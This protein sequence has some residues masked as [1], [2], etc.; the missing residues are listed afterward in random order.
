MAFIAL[1]AGS[2]FYD[3]ICCGLRDSRIHRPRAGEHVWIFHRRLITDGIAFTGYALN[4]MQ[5]RAVKPSIQS[6]PSIVVEVR[7]VHNQRISLPMSDGVSVIAKVR[8]RVVRAA[9][10]RH[11]TK[12]IPRDHLVEEYDGHPGGLNDGVRWTYARNTP[13][14]TKKGRVQ[15]ALV[16]CQVLYLFE[17]LR[18]VRRLIGICKSRS[19]SV[20]APPDVRVRRSETTDGRIRPGAARPK[21]IEI[22]MAVGES[23]YRPSRRHVWSRLW[24]ASSGFLLGGR[25]HGSGAQN[26]EHRHRCQA[27]LDRNL[28]VDSKTGTIV[29]RHFDVTVCVNTY[30]QRVEFLFLHR[31][32]ARRS[33]PG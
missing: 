2:I 19:S 16:T 8:L 6:K 13:R 28:L 32:A 33:Y 24:C 14:L 29:T 15:F 18:L 21:S 3:Q 27:G 20:V 7:T 11:K 9:I 22:R 10:G 31:P 5:C 25:G 17:Q 26:R 23:S 1:D 4:Y 12:R 30:S